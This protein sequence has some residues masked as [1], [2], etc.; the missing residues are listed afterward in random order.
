[1]YFEVGILYKKLWHARGSV[2]FKD[3]IYFVTLPC[4]FAVIENRL[5]TFFLT[6]LIAKDDV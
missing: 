5:C 4:I 2:F 6:M 1:M 3:F